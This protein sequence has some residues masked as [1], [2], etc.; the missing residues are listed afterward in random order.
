MCIHGELVEKERRRGSIIYSDL[1]CA[2]DVDIIYVAK[3]GKHSRKK[4]GQ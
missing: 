1:G 2:M 4:T 3:G